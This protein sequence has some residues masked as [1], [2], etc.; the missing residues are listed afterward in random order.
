MRQVYEDILEFVEENGP[1]Q[2]HC[3]AAHLGLPG[4]RTN[5]LLDNM[6]KTGLLQPK[7]VQCGNHLT[8]T[9]SA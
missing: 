5:D 7:A 4:E 9:W 3:I 8:R 1:V 6:M 2:T